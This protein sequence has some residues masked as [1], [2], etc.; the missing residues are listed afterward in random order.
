MDEPVFQPLLGPRWGLQAASNTPLG[1]RWGC[2]ACLTTRFVLVGVYTATQRPL[3]S[4]RPAMAA[5]DVREGRHMLSLT[6][7]DRVIIQSKL[8]PGETK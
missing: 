2:W 4:S 6:S 3:S 1:L 5:P 7:G 8:K